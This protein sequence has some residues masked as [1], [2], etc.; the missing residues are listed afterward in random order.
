MAEVD[1]SNATIEPYNSIPLEN[2][3]A[4]LAGL[5]PGDFGITNSS[6]TSIVSSASQT[7]LVDDYNQIVVKHSGTLNASGTEMYF[8][9]NGIRW[10]ISNIS[11]ASG[12]TFNFTT[13]ADLIEV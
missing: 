9:R 4:S 6:G 3:F 5:N 12:D 1:F 7:R 10:K 8:N 2:W 11:F 13:E